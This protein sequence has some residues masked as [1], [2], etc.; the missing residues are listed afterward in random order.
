MNFLDNNTFLF[1]LYFPY[2]HSL[3]ILEVSFSI[4]FICLF[5]FQF[6]GQSVGIVGLCWIGL[7][8]AKRAEAFG[9]PISYCFRADEQYPNYKYHSTIVD[10]ASNCQILILACNL[11]DETRHIVKC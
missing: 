7:A 11:S 5:V 8:I 10:F 4:L 9:C 2:V 6:S 1:N 3:P